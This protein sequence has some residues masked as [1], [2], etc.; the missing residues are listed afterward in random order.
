MNEV[1]NIG[2]HIAI[3]G[4]NLIALQCLLKE[5]KD[6]D[7]IY[8]DPP[9][10]TE[11]KYCYSD[12]MKREE[13]ESFMTERI[14]LARLLLSNKGVIFISISDRMAA[15]LRIICDGIFGEEYYVGTYFWERTRTPANSSPKIR[16]RFEYILCYEKKRNNRRFV[17]CE[18]EATD[19]PLLNYIDKVKELCF[20]EKSVRFDIPDGCY[21]LSPYCKIESDND[22]FVKDGYN[23]QSFKAKGRFKWIQ[24]KL[25][26]ELGKGTEIIIKS[27]KFSPRYK[28]V[29]S[30]KKVPSNVIDYSVGVGTNED[31]YKELKK[32]GFVFN[33]AKPVSLIKYLIKMS[34]WD[35]KDITILDFFAGSGTTLCATIELNTED[36]GTRKCSIVTNNENGIFDNITIKRIHKYYE[37]D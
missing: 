28:R 27:L 20:P 8:I 7:F 6:F 12:N 9:Y 4:E 32:E 2:E 31:S 1:F 13:W 15:K 11:N 23:L 19:C 35:E 30:F 16:T 26:D 14:R 36:G 18:R 25:D 33:Y 5:G 21:K 34:F 17:C 10:N 3:K 37:K 24:S 22:I 29:G